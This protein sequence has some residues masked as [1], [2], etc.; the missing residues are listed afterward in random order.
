MAFNPRTTEAGIW[1]NP[2]Y[3]DSKYT[4]FGYDSINAMPNCTAYAYGRSVE[5]SNGQI[6]ANTI[7]GGGF[8]GQA[9]TWY[10]TSVWNKSTNANDIKV[11]DI[12]CWS[13]GGGVGSAGHVAIVESITST[14]IYVSQSH[15]TNPLSESRDYTN[16]GTNAIRYFE[17]GYF[18]R[19]ATQFTG[20][21]HYNPNGNVGFYNG[22]Y[23]SSWSAPN[24]T[25]CIHNPYADGDTPVPPDPDPPTPTEAPT[26]DVIP[27]YYNVTMSKNEDYVD[28]SF[29]I[30][31]NNVPNGEK[32]SGGNTYPG[33]SRIYNSGWSYSGTTAFKTQTL[34]YYRESN[35]NYQI[36]KYMYFNLSFS[37][38]SIN[39]TIPMYINVE[40]KGAVL[41]MDSMG[42][43]IH[44]V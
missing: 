26:I 12:L 9:S 40:R 3:Y 43:D 16:P 34:R 6:T 8:I 23:P 27:E 41:F 28:F 21:Y 37:T 5:I 10:S 38:G 35:K 25:G 11:G 29:T 33:L 20:L 44:I 15:F 4:K 32:V 18:N 2:F 17:Y 24:F 42:I 39:E 22:T 7:F 31:V 1:N 13:E 19:S 14:R 30:Q 36:T